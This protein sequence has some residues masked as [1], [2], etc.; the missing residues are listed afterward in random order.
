M[1]IKIILQVM[2]FKLRI[3]GVTSNQIIHSNSQI[4]KM[5]PRNSVTSKVAKCL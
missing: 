1:F 2:V 4:C 5:V 3:S